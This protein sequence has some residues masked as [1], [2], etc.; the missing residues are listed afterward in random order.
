LSVHPNSPNFA[1]VIFRIF[2]PDAALV[3]RIIF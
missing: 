2:L 1:A 3:K